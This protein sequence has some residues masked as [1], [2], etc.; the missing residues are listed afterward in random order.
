MTAIRPRIADQLPLLVERL[1]GVE[2]PLRAHPVEA[3]RV[4]LELREIIQKRRRDPPLRA[5]LRLDPRFAALHAQYDPRR[6]LSVRRQPRSNEPAGRARARARALAFARA[7][8][9]A[10]R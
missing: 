6:L 2:R 9:R 3:V 4:A 8:T 1:R 10:L 7:L 5:G